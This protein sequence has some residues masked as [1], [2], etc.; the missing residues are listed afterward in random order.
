MEGNYILCFLNWEIVFVLGDSLHASIESTGLC[1][2]LTEQLAWES[3]PV[4]RLLIEEG[5][6]TITEWLRL[7]KTSGC[8]LVLPSAQAGPHIVILILSRQNNNRLLE[9]SDVC[10]Q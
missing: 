7:E 1:V 5:I 9:C 4:N 6:I 10:L 3:P 2:L 8:H